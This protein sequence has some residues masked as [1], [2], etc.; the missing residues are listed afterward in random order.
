MPPAPIINIVDDDASFRSAVTRL[1][2]A[3]GYEV[4]AFG[5]AAEF[6]QSPRDNS[7][8]CA[9]VDLKMPGMSGLELQSALAQQHNPIPLIFLTGHGE[10]PDSVQAMRRGAEDFLTKPVR[11]QILFEA[12]ERALCRD[13][14]ERAKRAQQSDLRARFAGL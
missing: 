9:I 5:S 3:A 11:R 12:V 1:L 4:R 6:L 8:G 14:V 7:P 10:I 13:Q 2:T